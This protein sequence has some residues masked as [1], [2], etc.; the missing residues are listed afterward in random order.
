M[1]NKTFGKNSLFYF[2]LGWVAFESQIIFVL[3]FVLNRFGIAKDT[4]AY[5]IVFYGIYIILF[6]VF[7]F[8]QNIKKRMKPLLAFIFILFFASFINGQLNNPYFLVDDKS[9]F[10]PVIFLLF[11]PS[12]AFLFSCIDDFKRAEV[13][14]IWFSRV[15]CWVS[16]LELAVNY[17]NSG[18]G[19]FYSMTLGY[20]LALSSILLFKSNIRKK[21]TYDFLLFLLT[22]L[23]VLLFGN[24]GAALTVVVSTIALYLLNKCKGKS[25]SYCIRTISIAFIVFLLL[26]VIKDF[27]ISGIDSVAKSFGIQSRTLE[28]LLSGNISD[29]N[30]RKAIQTSVM[31]N[32]NNMPFF[33]YGVLGDRQFAEGS[34]SHNIF[35]ELITSFG[36]L[37]GV[38]I[39]AFIALSLFLKFK[40]DKECRGLLLLIAAFVIVKMIISGSF[41]TET[42][43]FIFLGCSF[44]FRS[45]KRIVT[46][47]RQ[48]NR[49]L[50]AR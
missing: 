22:F 50:F 43:F 44:N 34:Y 41:A 46:K 12:V 3:T 35:I 27:L 6:L 24:R 36:Y 16:I 25:R 20:D 40:W 2:A 10:N 21:N 39:I 30:G 9:G 48:T 18:G 4:N 8:N 38:F 1:K 33:G 5:Q 7:L 31:N 29:D 32:W 14:L 26:F 47:K 15:L 37:F 42:M 11:L 49:F 19:I 13:A 23:L 45:T 17:L 28:K